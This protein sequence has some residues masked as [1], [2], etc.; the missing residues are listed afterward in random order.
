M[1]GE[2]TVD[3][4]GSYIYMDDL[5]AID[6]HRPAVSST[7]PA[8]VAVIS[9]PLIPHE[10]E[11]ALANHPDR[12]FVEYVVRGIREGFRIGYDYKRQPKI[13]R[14]KNMRSADENP[15]PVDRYVQE[16]VRAGRLIRL[17]GSA[18]GRVS[19]VGVIP[20]PH[21]PGKWRL[22][23]DLSFPKGDS[24]NDGISTELCSVSYA[25]VDDAVRC[26]K[27][28][29]R[30]ALM[31]KFDIAN[32]YRAV[33]VHPTDR[34][35]LGMSW[36]GVTYIDGALP[37]GLRSAPKLFTAVADAFMWALGGRDI[38]HAIHYLDDFLIVGPPLSTECGRALKESLVL[39]DRLGFPIA[40]HKVEGPQSKLTFLGIQI[41]TESET[42]ALPG[43]KLDRLKQAIFDWRSKK[44]CKKRELLSLIGQ[45]QHACRVV[46]SGRTF[47]RRMIDLSSSA[48]D[49][50]HWVRL[51]K[52]FRSDLHW[53]Y[54]FLD[55]WN[56]IAM[57][58]SV[59]QRPPE[60]TLTSDASGSWGCGAFIDSG[61]WFQYRWPSEYEGVHITSKELLPIVVGCAVW[62]KKWKSCTVR[63]LCDNAAVVAVVRS[64][65]SR[66]Q[67]VMHLLRCLFFFLAHHQIVLA[68]VH[69]PGR[70][71]EAAD[72][73]SRNALPS[74]RQLIPA[75]QADPTPLAEEL[76]AALVTEQPDWTSEAWRRV[77]HSTLRKV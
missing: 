62:G 45:L 54:L 39:C 34:M 30:G 27:T 18:P 44:Y 63:C 31:A 26:V 19:R 12:E 49:M 46:R 74:F 13:K 50:D 71:N 10:W 29:G 40:P 59:I 8:E 75:A 47:L 64:G 1:A 72:S 60:A 14:P 33:P 15:Q 66:D 70:L 42:L 24:V 4:E 53:W 52:E 9:S 17:Y 16:E 35:L 22:I 7:V 2:A 41:D 55:D 48:R 38:V 67:G 43:E 58:D 20:K 3:G 76:M 61:E 57:C 65:S 73:L 32:A 6:A 51:N 36:R 37:F 25:T 5:Q 56:G 23:T 11:A 68:P 21:Q 69:I 77:L 28:L